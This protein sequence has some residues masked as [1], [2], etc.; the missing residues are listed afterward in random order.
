MS[1]TIFT[2]KVKIPVAFPS[3]NALLLQAFFLAIFFAISLR[4]KLHESLL[5]VTW[6]EMIL[7]RNFVVVAVIVAKSRG[8]YFVKRWLQ[9]KHCGKSSFYGM[10]HYAR[11]RATS[12]AKVQWNC[13][14]SCKT[15]TLV[16]VK[17]PFICGFFFL[18]LDQTLYMC[19]KLWCLALSIPKSDLHLFSPYNFTTCSKIQGVENK[20]KP[21]P[22]SNVFI[23]SKF[24]QLVP[25][26][27]HGGR[28]T[29]AA[30][31]HVTGERVIIAPVVACVAGDRKSVV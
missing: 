26:E 23:P 3:F 10:L 12:V 9:Q 28:W 4:H 6:T 22:N 11:S 8:R 7:S 20:R 14:T 27:K 16:S 2:R 25:Q 21:S 18:T 15:Y 31:A 5:S 30:Q 19:C 24:S 1:C 13:E 17:V 29:Q